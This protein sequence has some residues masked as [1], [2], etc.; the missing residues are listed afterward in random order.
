MLTSFV[1]GSFSPLPPSYFTAKNTKAT[2]E[3]EI[4]ALRTEKARIDKRL[5]E[6]GA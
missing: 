4:A 5:K 2:R 6:L 3:A 1:T